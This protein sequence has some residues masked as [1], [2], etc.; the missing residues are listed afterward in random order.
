MVNQQ[1]FNFECDDRFGKRIE[2]LLSF[3]ESE[4]AITMSCTFNYHQYLFREENSTL[5]HFK[6]YK[7]CLMMNKITCSTAVGESITIKVGESGSDDQYMVFNLVKEEKDNSDKLNTMFEIMMKEI[8]ELKER[9]WYTDRDLNK[10]SEKYVSNWDQLTNRQRELVSLKRTNKK[11]PNLNQSSVN[12]TGFGYQV[13]RFAQQSISNNFQYSIENLEPIIIYFKHPIEFSKIECS[14]QV[15]EI[16][17]NEDIH[18]YVYGVI[19]PKGVVRSANPINGDKLGSSVGQLLTKIYTEPKEEFLLM[20]KL[21]FLE[22]Q[23]TK[24]N[25]ITSIQIKSS[26]PYDGIALA[27]RKAHNFTEAFSFSNVKI[28]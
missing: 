21:D 1:S 18:I 27:A 15:Q 6:Y 2:L 9:L 3:L 22:A 20:P 28:F 26:L 7:T 14:V 5:I 13:T 12:T 19:Q 25:T 17:G 4:Q 10:L 24:P 11:Y 8:T 16:T 23:P